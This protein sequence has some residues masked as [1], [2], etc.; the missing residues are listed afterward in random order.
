MLVLSQMDDALY[1]GGGE[2]FVKADR[3]YAGRQEIKEN[4]FQL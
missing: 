2:P 3:L 1:P 4:A